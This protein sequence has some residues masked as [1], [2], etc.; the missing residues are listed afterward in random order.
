[1]A[2]LEPKWLYHYTLIDMLSLIFRDPKIQFRRLDLAD[3]PNE[4][5]SSDLG[6]Q[7]KYVMELSAILLSLL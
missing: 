1:M 5:L 6:H 7:G 3:D 2:V 4:A